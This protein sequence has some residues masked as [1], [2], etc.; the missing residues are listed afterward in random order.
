MLAGPS[1]SLKWCQDLCVEEKRGKRGKRGERGERGEG[2][3]REEGEEGEEGEGGRRKR[4]AR[5]T[6]VRT[7]RYTNELHISSFIFSGL[8]CFSLR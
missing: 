8:G 1:D 3:E 4:E 6:L 7:R 2:G 5:V